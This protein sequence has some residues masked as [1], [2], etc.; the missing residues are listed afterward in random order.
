M[1][2]PVLNAKEKKQKLKKKKQF[3]CFIENPFPCQV[4]AERL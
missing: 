1:G 2:Y 4:Q 3:F